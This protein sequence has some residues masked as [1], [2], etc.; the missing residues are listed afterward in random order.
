PWEFGYALGASRPLSLKAAARRCTFCGQN[1]SAGVELYGGF[2]GRR[3]FWLRNTPPYLAPGA[4][5]RLPKGWT[6]PPSPGFCR[7][8]NSHRFLLR[9]GVSREFSG[10]GE[11]LQ[12]MFGGK[13]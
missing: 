11:L 3:S 7:N 9:W 4:A 10:F 13:P 2:G 6:R 5:L 12:R 1:F 8:D